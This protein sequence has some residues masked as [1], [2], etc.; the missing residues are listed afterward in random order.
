M[1]VW[2]CNYVC[3]QI[4]SKYCKAEEKLLNVGLL[5][6]LK[7]SHCEPEPYDMDLGSRLTKIIIAVSDNLVMSKTL[8]TV[9]NLLV[10]DGKFSGQYNCSRLIISAQSYMAERF[11]V[12][13]K[14]MLIKKEDIDVESQCFAAE[15]FKNGSKLSRP[16]MHSINRRAQNNNYDGITAS[17]LSFFPTNVL[18]DDWFLYIAVDQV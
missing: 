11:L 7:T 9:Q 10:V 14:L 1:N 15:E 13:C 8:N 4:I 17:G 12:K 18:H 5:D 3:S 16:S 6:L 2:S